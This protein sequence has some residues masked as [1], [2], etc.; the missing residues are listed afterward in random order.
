MK[1]ESTRFKLKSEFSKSSLKILVLLLLAF[2]SF[3]LSAQVKVSGTVSDVN[4][5]PLIGVNVVVKDA[6]IGTVTDVEGAY[7]L[8]VP[9]EN[10]VLVFSYI[11]YVT[12][13]TVVGSQT[14]INQTLNEET[15]MMDELVVVGYGIQKESNRNRCC[16]KCGR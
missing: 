6:A 15:Q 7:N 5:E 2:S 12:V 14:I 4:G 8:E 13:E 10:S 9:G 3:A 16:G 1:K 11:G